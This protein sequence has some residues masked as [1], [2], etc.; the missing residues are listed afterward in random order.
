MSRQQV[1]EEIKGMFGLVPTFF[2]SIP[3]SSLEPEWQL[4]KQTQFED[5]PISGKYRHLIGVGISAALRCRYCSLF[6]TEAA[7]LNGATDEEI[8]DA[9]H[10]AKTTASWTTYVNGMQTDFD[11][12]K[13]E[14]S[15][16]V[17]YA[18]KH[19]MAAV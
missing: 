18:Q 1:Y 17:S 5:G 11:Q 8:Q 16:M 4:M 12:F 19:Q 3:D 14:V 10:F 13:K 2:K 7:R 9:V 6:H 15:Q